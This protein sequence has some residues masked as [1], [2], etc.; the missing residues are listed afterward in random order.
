MS[1]MKKIIL[2]YALMFCA[3]LVSASPA[4][5]SVIMVGT[6]VVYPASLKE[7]VLNFTNQDNY[8]NL[9]Q[10][11]VDQGNGS[12]GSE[13]E[14]PPFV[15]HPPVFRMEPQAGQMVRLTYVGE[16][17]PQDRESLFFLNFLQVPAIKASD[18]EANKL[19]LTVRSRMKIFYRPTALSNESSMSTMRKSL[20]FEASRA[21]GVVRVVGRNSSGYYAVLQ[22]VIIASDKGDVPVAEAVL[23]PPK[24]E[25]V[26][27]V[28]TMTGE[29]S[30]SRLKV[31][32]I[33]D[34][35][36]EIEDEYRFK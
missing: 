24:G 22:S 2:K 33:N 31:R 15:A 25:V 14:D 5:A 16:T 32:L 20:S 7:R 21:D 34:Y 30:A 19:V 12:S 10:I 27:P 23:I 13:S 8:P 17:L 1:N 28:K 36:G 29:V 18:M 35:G 9:V 11:W 26:W 6:R 3:A 4:H